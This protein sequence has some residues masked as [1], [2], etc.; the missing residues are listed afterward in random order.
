MIDFF[1]VNNSPIVIAIF[2][3][4]EYLEN[5]EVDFSTGNLLIFDF[6]HKN[7]LLETIEIR[8]VDDSPLTL[9]I[10]LHQQV[11]EI[12]VIEDIQGA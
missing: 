5:I 2:L 7:Q 1:V 3:N 12:I 6:Y 8:K 11:I 9:E 4:G 10:Y